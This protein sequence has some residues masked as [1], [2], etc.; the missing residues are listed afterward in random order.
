MLFIPFQQFWKVSLRPGYYSS[1]NPSLPDVIAGVRNLT[2]PVAVCRKTGL[3]GA[4]HN[5]LVSSLRAS[6]TLHFNLRNPLQKQSKAKQNKTKTS[7]EAIK[8]FW[9]YFHQ[10]WKSVGVM[11]QPWVPQY[12]RAF[13]HSFW[14]QLS[15][16]C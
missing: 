3:W 7:L 4:G 2:E 12:P 5:I 14:R 8:I 1:Y 15:S 13:L 6:L 16:G 11:P 10:N 9:F